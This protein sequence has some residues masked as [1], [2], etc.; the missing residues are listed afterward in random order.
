[1]REVAEGIWEV[2]ILRGFVNV[3]VVLGESVA[4]IDAGLPGRAREV[5]SAVERLGRPSR[6]VATIVMTHHHIDHSGALASLQR[7]TGAIVYASAPEAAILEGTAPVPKL[8]SPSRR[9]S[10]LLALAERIGPTVPRPTEVHHRLVDGEDI[11]AAGLVSVFTPGHTMGHVSYLH[12]ATGTLFAG[13]AA[14]LTPRGHLALPAANHDE[15]PEATLASIHKLA[16]LDF[17]VACF[18]HGGT[19][20]HNA[21]AAM[22]RFADGLRPTSPRQGSK[23][24]ETTKL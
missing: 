13:D 9:W 1:M 7:E 18:A 3:Y 15:D 10:L 12:P 5:I 23:P 22:Q 11:Q 2:P 24:S 4:V 20:A 21:R 8:V 19:L 14:S 16:E 6:D 17:Q